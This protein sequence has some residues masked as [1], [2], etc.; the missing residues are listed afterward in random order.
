MRT[1]LLAAA[2]IL[3]GAGDPRADARYFLGTWSCAG[4]Y[5]HWS[6][7]LGDD[8]W[9]RNVYG[10]AKQPDGTAVMGWVPE[11][12]AFVYRDFH[13]DG[14][15]ADLTSP[16]AVNGR[17]E[18][19]GPYYPAAGGPPLQGRITYVVVSPT[20]YDRI[21]EMQRAGTLTRMGGDN[22]RKPSSGLTR[23]RSRRWGSNPRPS[24]YK[25]DALATELRRRV[26]NVGDGEDENLGFAY[27]SGSPPWV[28]GR[29][30]NGTGL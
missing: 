23:T 20:R 24:T 10:D 15:Y 26:A 16:G 17:W 2:V 8:R 14:S 9:I 29:V 25:V 1:L 13:A 19:S 12:H 27:Q 22:A 3:L 30:V 18:W 11:L 6:P 21:F 7:L 4:T 28:G 5:W